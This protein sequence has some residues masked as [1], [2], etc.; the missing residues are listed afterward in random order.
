MTAC[1]IA[2]RAHET[3]DGGTCA[4]GSYHEPGGYVTLRCTAI[5]EAHAADATVVRA[6]EID[7]VCFERD[8]G[9]GSSRRVDEHP[10]DDGT[11]RRIETIDVILWLDLHLDD[12][13]A[14]VK[15]RRSDDGR[16]CRLDSVQHAPSR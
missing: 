15:R 12:L 7:E 8:F 9:A 1:S 4:V 14:V 13:V 6:D 16:T 11:P 5:P 2:L 3:S 10:I